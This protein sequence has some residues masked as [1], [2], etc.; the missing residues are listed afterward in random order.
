MLG[1]I[2]PIIVLIGLYFIYSQISSI[3]A[4]AEQIVN[5]L[6][7][8]ISELK[9]KDRT[10]EENSRLVSRY[11]RALFRKTKQAAIGPDI[12]HRRTLVRSLSN[13]KEVRQEIEIQSKDNIKKKS[14][15]KKKVEIHI[16][17]C[18]IM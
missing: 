17:C 9:D 10:A 11:L 1:I 12:S 4:F 14:D 8:H 13:D 15:R 16:V 2:L 5:I 18:T 6:S 7:N 3:N